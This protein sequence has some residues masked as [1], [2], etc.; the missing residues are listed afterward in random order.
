MDST[1]SS[2]RA[3]N[4]RGPALGLAG[5]DS[6]RN[7]PS[8]S[9]PELRLLLPSDSFLSPGPLRLKMVLEEAPEPAGAA[10]SREA[11]TPV[12]WFH[13]QLPLSLGLRAWKLA[14]VSE[15]FRGCQRGARFCSAIGTGRK[16]PGEA[17]RRL[18]VCESLD[19]ALVH[20]GVSSRLP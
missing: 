7:L 12:R 20:G 13:A 3:E 18:H 8:D 2:F 9:V 11:G 1:R 17:R 4:S 5:V 16:W 19:A 15:R 10:G 6:S 14:K